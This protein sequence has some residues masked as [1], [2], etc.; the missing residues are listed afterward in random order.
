MR[1]RDSENSADQPGSEACPI[2]GIN[3]FNCGAV[4]FTQSGRP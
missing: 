4:F 1:I 3:Q 2:D